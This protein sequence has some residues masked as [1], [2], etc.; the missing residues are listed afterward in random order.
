MCVCVNWIPVV[1][2]K[3]TQHC[4]SAVCQLQKQT[5]K[6]TK[7]TKKRPWGSR[8]HGGTSLLWTLLE[9]QEMWEFA[10]FSALPPSL[11][12]SLASAPANKPRLGTKDAVVSQTVSANGEVYLVVRRFAW[13]TQLTCKLHSV[14][15]CALEENVAEETAWVHKG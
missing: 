5:N 2:L 6:Q 4:Q 8:I 10:S 7:K 1:H 15:V 3:L 9:D 13:E 11:P 14:L 12:C